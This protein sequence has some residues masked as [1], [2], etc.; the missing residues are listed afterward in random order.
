ML[1]KIVII[2]II[3]CSVDFFTLIFIPE[4]VQKGSDILALGLTAGLLV[5]M[6]FYDTTNPLPKSFTFPIV[7]IFISVIISMFAAYALQEQGFTTT[8]WGQRAVYYFLVYFLI[9]EQAS[10]ITGQT[11]NIDGGAH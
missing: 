11:I 5:L 2:L 6:Y 8:F 7:L 9:S 4:A 10:Y 1:K 3:L